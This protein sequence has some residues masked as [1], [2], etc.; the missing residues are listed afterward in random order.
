MSDP[1]LLGTVERVAHA[2]EE[3]VRLLGEGLTLLREITS[4]PK[5]D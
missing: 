1:R 3:H 5:A 4:E 2:L